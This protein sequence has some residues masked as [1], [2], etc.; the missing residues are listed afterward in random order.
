MCVH[1]PLRV[2]NFHGVSAGNVHKCLPKTR[3]GKVSAL[4]FSIDK[5]ERTIAAKAFPHA[6]FKDPLA[7]WV[8]GHWANNNLMWSN[9][10]LHPNSR[11]PNSREVIALDLGGGS[12]E[13]R[14]RL[15]RENVRE[16]YQLPA[17]TPVAV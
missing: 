8:F 13:G 16:L 7:R 12:D 3:I 5:S 10:Y 9:D 15:P 1:N 2:K 6:G 14:T 4:P 17:L 11:W